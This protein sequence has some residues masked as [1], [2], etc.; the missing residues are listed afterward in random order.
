MPKKLTH[1]RIRAMALEYEAGSTLRDIAKRHGVSPMTVSRAF[2]EN[3]IAR[4]SSGRRVLHV[5]ERRCTL[6]REVK[7]I[8]EFA[9]DSRRAIGYDYVCKACTRRKARQRNIET[10]FGMTM[11]E[12]GRL[13]AEQ[14]GG[15]AICGRKEA[16]RRHGQPIRLAVDHDHKTGRVRGLF[17]TACNVAVGLLDDNPRRLRNAAEYLE[18][19]QR[20]TQQEG[21]DDAT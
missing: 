14:G 4:R 15:C 3:G 13:E 11:K 9:K 2:Q 17:C 6:C 20:N 19:H 21:G 5:T 10:K 1:Q 16:R 12:F 18:K 7:P 8:G